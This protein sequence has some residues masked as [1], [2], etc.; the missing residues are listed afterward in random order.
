[1]SRSY[2]DH[3]IYSCFAL[4]L[5]VSKLNI[6]LYQDGLEDKIDKVLAE[7]PDG[8]SKEEIKHEIRSNHFMTNKVIEKLVED[9]LVTVEA[10][11]GR[12]EV[13]IT[14]EGVLY[15]RKYNEFFLSM[16]REQI[17]E[18]YQYRGIPH[19]ARGKDR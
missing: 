2:K 12:Y 10:K 13:R 5:L 16:Y 11:E 9:K 8:V 14:R 4:N 6:D 7:H 18:H 15:I 17:E 3:K 1:M 19:W